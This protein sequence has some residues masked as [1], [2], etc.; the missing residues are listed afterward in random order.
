M[1]KKERQWDA[2]MLCERPGGFQTGDSVR[3][4]ALDNA[5]NEQLLESSQES[6]LYAAYLVLQQPS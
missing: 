5:L 3:D 1:A 4:V 6:Y 2:L